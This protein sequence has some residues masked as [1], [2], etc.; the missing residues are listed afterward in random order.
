MGWGG[1][2]PGGGRACDGGWGGVGVVGGVK[3][4]FFRGQSK[5]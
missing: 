3:C 4:P 1:V 2:G 5:S